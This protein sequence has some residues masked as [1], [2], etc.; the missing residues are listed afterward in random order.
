MNFEYTP[1]QQMLR[2]AV[3]R[4]IR[5]R[6]DLKNRRALKA[7]NSGFS[8]DN[9]SALAAMGLLG[10]PFAEEDGGIGG[11]AVEKMIVMEAIGH[12]AALEPYLGTVILAGG[13]LHL[14]AADPR[15]RVLIERI[16]AGEALVAFA[17]EEAAA[18]YCGS[19]VATMAEK[20]A[21]GWRLSGQKTAVL[22]GN[23]A[24]AFIISA[25]ISG[26][27]RDEDGIC[28]FLLPADKPGVSRRDYENFDGT[29]ACVLDLNDVHLEADALIG[30][31]G[32]AWPVIERTIDNGIA[33]ICSEAVGA[34]DAMLWATVDY[35]KTRTQ[36]G[37][38]IGTFQVL[39][40]RA[41]EMYV[42]LEQARSMAIFAAISAEDDDRLSRRR[43]LAAAKIQI[44][45]SARFVGQQAV[46]L[47]G[48]V[49]FTEEVFITHH[50][51]RTTAIERQFG[52][53]EHHLDTLS[54]LGGLSIAA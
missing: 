39:Q 22:A 11:G 48:G 47:H 35:L 46:Q 26:A 43:A 29:R 50:F 8:A 38:T 40:H 36:F 30:P 42:K 19:H 52:D 4:L 49:G 16:A 20:T 13:A 45:E 54:R 32:S 33:A 25:R 27:P 7:S 28:L 23:V 41:A 1:E 31:E 17:H 10:L 37:V 34:M 44:N 12:G 15:H 51:R 5:D 18:R 53:T 14:G 21:S 6:N 24:E 3:S 2:D 9:W